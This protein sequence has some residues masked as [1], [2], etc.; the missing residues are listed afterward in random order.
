MNA[1]VTQQGIGITTLGGVQLITD[2]PVAPIFT[3]FDIDTT[4]ISQYANSPTILALIENF[5]AYFDP[6]PNMT[7]FY[8]VMWNILTAEGFGLDIWGRIL[9]VSRYLRLPNPPT[10][11]FGFY[12][13]GYDDTQPFN[14]APF[15]GGTGST[16]TYELSDEAYL[17]L[18]MAKAFANICQ[19]TIPVMNQLLQLLFPG[20]GNSYVVDLGNMQMQYVFDWQLSPTQYAIVLN[21]GVL[22]HP[23][24][25]SVAIVTP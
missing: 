9:G 8:N 7:S 16:E 6:V 4:V 24:G 10:G 2:A 21:S 23:T 3:E 12:D 11:Y 14:V 18:L 13:G 22:P 17:P 19:T 25:V 20:A 5:A 15:Y 1:I